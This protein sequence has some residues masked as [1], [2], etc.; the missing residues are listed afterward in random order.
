MFPYI[1]AICIV[2]QFR[3]LLI[4]MPQLNSLKYYTLCAHTYH[5]HFSQW[6]VE[7]KYYTL[8][9]HAYHICSWQWV[10]I[11][12]GTM[13]LKIHLNIKYVIFASTRMYAYIIIY[14]MV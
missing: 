13:L 2:L 7:D 5:I 3:N 6:L 11:A 14:C 10:E 9:S 1:H 8:C 4:K 12:K